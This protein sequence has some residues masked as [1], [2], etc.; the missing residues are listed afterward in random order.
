MWTEYSTWKYPLNT[1]AYLKKFS[2]ESRETPW[3]ISYTYA[4]NRTH[5]VTKA[6]KAELSRWEKRRKLLVCDATKVKRMMCEVKT[7]PF[8]TKVTANIALC[9]NF[10]SPNS[11]NHCMKKVLWNSWCNFYNTN[12]SQTPFVSCNCLRFSILKYESRSARM[13]YNKR[14]AVSISFIFSADGYALINSNRKYI[15]LSFY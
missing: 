7:R 15:K 12:S 1:D 3:W 14:H 11:T 4:R 10:P 8:C 2:W 13:A 9:I 5:E 6:G